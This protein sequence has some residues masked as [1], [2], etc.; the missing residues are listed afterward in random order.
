MHRSTTLDPGIALQIGQ[1]AL[2]RMEPSAAPSDAPETAAKY[3][4]A[5]ELKAI[6][7]EY[8]KELDSV[9]CLAAFLLIVWDKFV[10]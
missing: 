3:A 2:R 9:V 7:T 5:D 10:F 8:G 1:G 6:F 4:G